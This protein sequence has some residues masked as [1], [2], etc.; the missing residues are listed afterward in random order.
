MHHAPPFISPTCVSLISLSSSSWAPSCCRFH[1]GRYQYHQHHH[2][3]S[4]TSSQTAYIYIWR[5]RTMRGHYHRMRSW[6]SDERAE[7]AT[8]SMYQNLHVQTKPASEVVVRASIDETWTCFDPPLL[9]PLPTPSSLQQ[10]LLAVTV[11]VVCCF[12]IGRA[13]QLSMC[14]VFAYMKR[15]THA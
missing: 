8:H 14:A 1:H 15:Y 4:P 2:H 3:N 7:G 13:D 10:P 9:P 5:C 11:L 12:S 6:G